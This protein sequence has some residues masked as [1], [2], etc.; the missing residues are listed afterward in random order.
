LIAIFAPDTLFE[1]K[2]F[3]IIAPN[4]PSAYQATIQFTPSPTMTSIV[5]TISKTQE[6]GHKKPV[7]NILNIPQ[8]EMQMTIKY[9]I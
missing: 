2:C 7:F 3:F 8:N 5:P 9:C 4:T 6:I 1:Q